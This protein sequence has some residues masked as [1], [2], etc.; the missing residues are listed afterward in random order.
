MAIIER[1]NVAANPRGAANPT[2]GWG[3]A[4]AG[5]LQKGYAAPGEQA[6]PA[7]TVTNLI[8]NPSFEESLAG[9]SSSG[10]LATAQTTAGGVF[11]LE[12][13]CS[14]RL[15]VGA[16]AGIFTFAYQQVTGLIGGEYLGASFWFRSSGG[17]YPAASRV[18][19]F[20]D[21]N[22]NVGT[23][24]WSPT[25]TSPNDW[26]EVRLPA[27][28][29]PATA[30]KAN[31]YLY[32]GDPAN[33]V[34]PVEGAIYNT[35]CW[36]AFTMPTAEEVNQALADRYFDGDVWYPEVI[37]ADW[38]GASG[39][40][41]ST[42]DVAS[43]ATVNQVWNP[44]AVEGGIPPWPWANVTEAYVTDVVQDLIPGL[45]TGY[46]YTRDVASGT[47]LGAFDSP[48]ESHYCDVRPGESWGGGC[49]VVPS[50][51]GR[52]VYAVLRW[53]TADG[54]FISYSTG[55]ETVTVAGEA[56]WL[57]LA[58]VAPAQARIVT[59]GFVNLSAGAALGDTFD[60]TA[61]LLTPGRTTAPAVEDYFDGTFGREGDVYDRYWAGLE[62]ASPSVR[63]LTIFSPEDAPVD[64][65][66][67][68]G[69]ANEGGEVATY[70]RHALL[71]NF[72]PVE[73]GVRYGA[74]MWVLTAGAV[75]GMINRVRGS[76][77]DA[78]G[79]TIPG[80]VDFDVA[81]DSTP[82][83]GWSF[84]SGSTPVAP[85]GA[86]LLSLFPWWYRGSG[87]VV[88]WGG[89]VGW[90]QAMLEPGVVPP[91]PYFDG[92]MED[93]L[94]A[95]YYTDADG[96]S[97]VVYNS[98]PGKGAWGIE[99][100]G[101]GL[102]GGDGIVPTLLAHTVLDGI[103]GCL[104]EPPDGLGLPPRRTQD[105]VLAQR[106]GVAMLADFY[107]NRIITLKVTVSGGGCD[108]CLTAKQNVRKLLQAWARYCG[109]NQVMTIYTD[110]HGRGDIADVGPYF[111]IGRGRAAEVVWRGGGVQVADVTLRF[112]CV[113]HL[114][115]FNPDPEDQ[116]NVLQSV[117]IPVLNEFLVNYFRD[118]RGID[119]NTARWDWEDGQGSTSSAIL[120]TEAEDG[121]PVYETG[122]GGMETDSLSGGSFN[123]QASNYYRRRITAAGT[124]V[125]T[126]QMV[127]GL[128]V[129]TLGHKVTG[130]FWVRA[131]RDISYIANMRVSGA[132]ATII[133]S[134]TLAAGV[135]TLLKGEH[136]ASLAGGTNALLQ[137]AVTT[138]GVT[139][140]VDLDF[141]GV[142]IQDEDDPDIFFDGTPGF[143]PTYN[144]VDPGYIGF[145]WPLQ[146]DPGVA[147]NRYSSQF[148]G[149][150]NASDSIVGV[151]PTVPVEV[152][153]D[154]CVKMEVQF[155]GPLTG[156][157]SL[158]DVANSRWVSYA[159]D[160]GAGETA[161]L[162]TNTG[163]MFHAAAS[164]S[165]DTS[166]AL[167][168][169]TFMALDPSSGLTA[170]FQLWT[171][172]M[173]NDTGFAR[174]YWSDAVLGI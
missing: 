102:E 158:V 35:D 162:D 171:G 10:S 129:P 137:M 103:V 26:V 101:Y 36:R 12:G 125:S 131:S 111:A 105:V 151:A 106:D 155:E 93:T 164:S 165:G 15:A 46:R 112:D 95:W 98:R 79:G 50:V 108:G 173:N 68:Y 113:D 45:T 126:L 43:D 65:G 2:S 69:I 22:T 54:T 99:F 76:W 19:F 18:I 133:G 109:G 81:L 142:V 74:S 132:G 150:S 89:A 104:N 23:S 154:T 115:R 172:D 145:G 91:G 33:G 25:A 42:A 110:C 94:D 39:T 1:E 9:V 123:E 84:Y 140:P 78:A 135:W 121:W 130:R 61:G 90:T 87:D 138:A 48:A 56:L 149:A 38:D 163:R 62:N 13:T 73:P 152:Q 168:G 170:N 41:T 70:A 143:I 157:I 141:G 122:I 71:S 21:A 146:S 114:L 174:I 156:P 31:V 63:A 49:L 86:A 75:G 11:S 82:A 92:E 119:G 58:D 139:V 28:Q 88:E 159:L 8:G 40:S 14:M 118:P 107:E 147:V 148:A 167:S 161:V 169:D 17:T 32:V 72:S 97:H 27:Q 24:A 144:S 29:I 128:A 16:G 47:F 166:Y 3:G 5:G 80:T 60:M 51:S 30:T 127:S 117:D 20:D 6:Y 55:P 4:G 83:E 66:F 64:V 96:V 134:G 77:R 57:S 44:R 59:V 136:V 124:T 116:H 160:I 53:G 34:L 100:G 120:V 85:E 37:L 67:Q 153:G 7:R 52:T